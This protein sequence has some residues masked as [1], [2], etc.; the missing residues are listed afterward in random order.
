MAQDTLYNKR[1]ITENTIQIKI[2]PLKNSKIGF[3]E[4]PELQI[5]K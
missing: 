2:K 1:R 3:S 4:F 5:N